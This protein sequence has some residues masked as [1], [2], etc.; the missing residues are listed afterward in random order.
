MEFIGGLNRTGDRICGRQKLDDAAFSGN[1]RAT[2]QWRER[3]SEFGHPRLLRPDEMNRHERG[4]AGRRQRQLLHMLTA[5]NWIDQEV[6]AHPG[7]G[8]GP[9]GKDVDIAARTQ[10]GADAG[11]RPNLF[12]HRA[13]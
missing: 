10:P 2:I 12:P 1:V 4:K 5:N 7:D 13:V 9:G 11:A 3:C 6:V 8:V